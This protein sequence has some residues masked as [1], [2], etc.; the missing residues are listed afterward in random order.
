MCAVH[1]GTLAVGLCPRC[2]AYMCAWCQRI[3]ELGEIYCA[4]CMERIGGGAPV[5]WDRRQELGT[6]PALWQ[7][8][9]ESLL[10][11]DDFF[12]RATHGLSANPPLL[13]AMICSWLGQLG[14]AAIQL[15][16]SQGR[17][18]TAAGLVMVPVAVLLSVYVGGGI[19]HL[20]ARMFGGQG[21][22]PVTCRA[23]AFCLGASAL[24]IVPGLGMMVA[25]IYSIVLQVFAI[26]HAHRL[27]GG[28]AAAAVLLPLG[29]IM[30]TCCL[31]LLAVVGVA[32]LSAFK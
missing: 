2:G 20:L 9:K 22:Y 30:V 19:A 3:N 6:F 1:P 12:A 17:I 18:E 7:T 5:P 29:I 25:S 15:A 24:G 31:F 28:R 32:G 23:W 13:Y 16:M 8:L 11:P 14:Y 26:K 10:K 27:S 21:T 4:T